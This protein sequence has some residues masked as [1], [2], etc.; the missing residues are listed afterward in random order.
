MLATTPN[1]YKFILPAATPVGQRIPNFETIKEGDMLV[2]KSWVMQGQEEHYYAYRIIR[3]TDKR[4]IIQKKY[5][6]KER[7]WEFIQDIQL[8]VKRSPW[9]EISK[10]PTAPLIVCENKQ[11]LFFWYMTA[12]QFKETQER[13]HADSV[14]I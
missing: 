4:V 12:E 9:A 5:Y 7:G 10:T 2:L 14:S 6:D 1:S 8:R 11:L 13:L 3:K